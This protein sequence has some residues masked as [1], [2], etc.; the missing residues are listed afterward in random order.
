M[1]GLPIEQVGAFGEFLV[2]RLP[3]PP[4][5]HQSCGSISPYAPSRRR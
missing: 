3:A 2:Q 1:C 4:D 5:G